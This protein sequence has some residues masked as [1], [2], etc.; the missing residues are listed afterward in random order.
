VYHDEQ[1]NEKHATRRY[2]D[3]KEFRQVHKVGSRWVFGAGPVK[4]IYH[5]PAVVRAALA[6]Q[7]VWICDG[8]KD[9]DAMAE[10]GAVAT[11]C[12][13]GM[14]AWK[15]LTHYLLDAKVIIVAD[16]DGGAGNKQAQRLMGLL[17]DR[18]LR[19]VRAAEGK[20]AADHFMA[21]YG[22]NDFVTLEPSEPAAENA[23]LQTHDVM[24][25]VHKYIAEVHNA[26]ARQPTAFNL[27]CQLRDDG[28]SKAD[29]K[30]GLIFYWR[31]V[32]DMGGEFKWSE[33]AH[34]WNSAHQQ[35]RREPV[36]MR[37][38]GHSP[39]SYEERKQRERERQQIL[40][41]LKA[42]QRGEI[43]Y[44]VG[45]SLDE[46]LLMPNGHEPF[47]IHSLW[48]T[49]GKVL[50][51]AQQKAGKTTM[52]ANLL[53]AL[54]NGELFLGMYDIDDPLVGR[55]GLIDNEMDT[56]QLGGLLG[57]IGISA[58]SSDRVH[59]WALRG[60]SSTFNLIDPELRLW[61]IE[62]FKRWECEVIILDVLGVALNSC[63]FSENSNDEVT[64]FFSIW[65]E[66]T[67]QAGV[68]ETLFV[69]HMGHEQARARGASRLR[70]G[71]DV[72]WLIFYGPDEDGN[73]TRE[74]FFKSTGRADIDHPE[75]VLEFNRAD[76]SLRLGTLGKDRQAALK[77]SKMLAALVKIWKVP[78]QPSGEY[79]NTKHDSGLMAMLDAE[80]YVLRTQRPGSKALLCELTDL[81]LECVKQGR[82]L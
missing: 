13:D 80:G 38:M 66:I 24:Y 18:V 60:M 46:L 78:G 47:R 19:C 10:L 64:T 42:E 67:A 37:G 65:D 49:N 81:G 79:Y 27:S 22:L 50:L 52:V 32:K 3:K 73:P 82:I 29:A 21:G 57:G 74:R 34:A 51:T 12:P 11:C 23:G 25:W 36:A 33:V 75:T 17:G 72:E 8:E 56:M 26:E 44:P 28:W 53:R 1:E 76:H 48:P 16:Q 6:H 59:G 5:L 7:V 40:R 54:V 71:I 9:C 15:G 30:P 62:E 77:D 2:L 41:E 61:W 58:E 4:Y 31:A 68:S 45:W 69:H 35:G 55:V 20:D 14:G 63:G 39:M 70:G 43:K